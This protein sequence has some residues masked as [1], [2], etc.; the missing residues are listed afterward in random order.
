MKA[1]EMSRHALTSMRADHTRSIALQ[2]RRM[3]S[4]MAIPSE[5]FDS[6]APSATVMP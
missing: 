4:R 1:A 5:K 3:S 6:A 2:R